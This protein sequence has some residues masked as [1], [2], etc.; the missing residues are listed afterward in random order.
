MFIK[1]ESG[2]S[3]LSIYGPIGDEWGGV[4][5]KQVRDELADL[6]AGS[7]LDVFIHSQGGSVFDGIA[8][9]GIL[10]DYDTTAIVEG[11]AAS[12]ASVIALSA[13]RVEMVEGAAL[14]IHNPWSFAMGE[15]DDMRKTADLLD[16][17]KA[18]LVKKYTG[19]LGA[20]EAEISAIM[21]KE[22]W[23]FSDEAVAKGY[24]DAIRETKMAAAALH[25]IEGFK[26][27]ER[28][29]KLLANIADT[30]S[31]KLNGEIVSNLEQLAKNATEI[32]ELRAKI[33][34]AEKVKAEFEAKQK[35]LEAAKIA[36]EEKLKIVERSPAVVAAKAKAEA[37]PAEEVDPEITPSGN[38]YERYKAISDPVARRDYYRQ[39]QAAILAA[40]DRSLRN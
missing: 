22:T 36:A 6:P 16:A 23:V 4:T 7:G 11:L 21:D 1:N 33:E 15:A 30:Y 31:E 18:Q 37:V 24:A 10:S 3:I 38:A 5:A 40:Q 25:N 39:N 2:R 12:M 14:M 35:D 19:R 29:A 28:A 8:I 26:A 13:K 27:P 20:D 32:A 17:I 9:A 34:T